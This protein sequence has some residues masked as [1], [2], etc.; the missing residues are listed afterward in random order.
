[1][2][3]TAIKI[4]LICEPEVERDVETALENS[5]I[6]IR[7]EKLKTPANAYSIYIPDAIWTLSIALN[8]LEAK[9]D[10]ITGNVELSD[11]SKYELT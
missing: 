3:Q 2:S 4:T 7:K 1:M 9:K 11:G 8:I 10:V 6:P 5:Q